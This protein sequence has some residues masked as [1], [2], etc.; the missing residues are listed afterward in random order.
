MIKRM[1]RIATGVVLVSI[2]MYDTAD[3]VRVSWH[4]DI[5]KTG[6]SRKVSRPVLDG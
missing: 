4:L 2:H 6:Q 5:T 3:D 1:E